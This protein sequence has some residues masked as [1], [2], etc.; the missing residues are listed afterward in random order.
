MILVTSEADP[1]LPI[2]CVFSSGMEYADKI[3]FLKL[4]NPG[5]GAGIGIFQGAATLGASWAEER[6]AS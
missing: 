3:E 1:P 6:G 2:V 5:S 4:P